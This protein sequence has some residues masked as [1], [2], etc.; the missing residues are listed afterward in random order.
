MNFDCWTTG[1]WAAG[2]WVEGSWC[3][4]GAPAPVSV[5]GMAAIWQMQRRRQEEEEALVLA[6]TETLLEE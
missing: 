3:P 2:S 5:G 4:G 6:L 1:A